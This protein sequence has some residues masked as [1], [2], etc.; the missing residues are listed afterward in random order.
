[1]FSFIEAEN[2]IQ[3]AFAQCIGG[4]FSVVVQ[5]LRVE[6][7]CVHP[8]LRLRSIKAGSYKAGMDSNGRSG[9]IKVGDLYAEEVRDFLIS[10]DIPVNE[11]EN[12]MPLVKF[13]LIH[14]DPSC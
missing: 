3:D 12:E 9:F 6:V 1:M 8:V 5:E 11:S 4:H 2:V 13:R 10:M 14:K 7:E